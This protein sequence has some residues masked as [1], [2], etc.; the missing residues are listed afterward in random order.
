MLIDVRKNNSGWPVNYKTT[1][2]SVIPVERSHKVI[3]TQGAIP[4]INGEI[5]SHNISENNISTKST[6]SQLIVLREDTNLGIDWYFLKEAANQ[7][8]E[9]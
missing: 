3:Y 9:C 6:I 8:P 2:M 1:I 7:F 5:L 4:Y